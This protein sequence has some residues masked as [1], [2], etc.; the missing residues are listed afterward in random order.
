MCSVVCILEFQFEATTLSFH[1]LEG[2]DSN[3]GYWQTKGSIG[4][5]GLSDK[6][7]DSSTHLPFFP[8]QQHDSDS[9]HC[10]HS[11][12]HSQLLVEPKPSCPSSSSAVW[13]TRRCSE[14]HWSAEC[15]GASSKSSWFFALSP[16][17]VK[18]D[19]RP[20]WLPSSLEHYP[21]NQ[22]PF[23]L[24]EAAHASMLPSS[25]KG[26]CFPTIPQRCGQ[27]FLLPQDYRCYLMRV[28]G[29]LILI[30]MALAKTL[31]P[32]HMA[33][34]TKRCRSKCRD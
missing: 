17:C 25:I 34:G 27:C 5:H 33:L 19:P 3:H 22:F 13:M 12:S 4:L 21:R 18:V 14:R 6:S 26:R 7:S 2:P 20:P 1:M 23:W 16:G 9:L 15:G 24:S 30:L 11:P 28:Q 31:L 29:I 8:V 10:F 32:G